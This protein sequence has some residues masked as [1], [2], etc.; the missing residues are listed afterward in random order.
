MERVQIEHAVDGN[1]NRS[2]IVF[3]GWIFSLDHVAPRRMVH[4]AFVPKYDG[5]AVDPSQPSA[6]T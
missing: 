2:I 5:E 1:L 4:R 3:V 6:R